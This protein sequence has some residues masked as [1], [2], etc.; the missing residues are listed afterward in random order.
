MGQIKREKKKT[1]TWYLLKEISVSIPTV[2]QNEGWKRPW[3]LQSKCKHMFLFSS[4]PKN[5]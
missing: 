5:Q 2:I 4:Q 3:F 1:F